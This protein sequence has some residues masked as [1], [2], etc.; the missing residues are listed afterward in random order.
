MAKIF[1]IIGF[2]IIV[3]AGAFFYFKQNSNN[4]AKLNPTEK[5]P[6]KVYTLG[7]IQDAN[8]FDVAYNGFVES[9]ASQGFKEGVNLTL[10]HSVVNGASESAKIATNQYLQQKVDLIVTIGVS[11]TKSA[12]IARKDNTTPIVFF[13]V[14]DPINNKIINSYQDPGNNVT[15]VDSSQNKLAPLRL[16]FLKQ[17]SPNIKKTLVFYNNPINAGLGDLEKAAQELKINLVEKKVTSL[18][19]LKKQINSINSAEFDS[20]IRTPD[21]VLAAGNQLLIDLSIRYKVPYIGTN[22]S[23]ADS[24][25]LMSYGPSYKDLGIQGASLAVQIL[26]GKSANSL[27]VQQADRPELVINKK[28]AQQINLQFPDEI[29]RKTNKVIE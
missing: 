15:G 11:P 17:V 22:S 24:G 1:L 27:P 10:L 29:L 2:I 28:T 12:Q 20:V 16:T 18:D 23:D 14:S 26:K 5:K 13:V 9:L 19:D 4:L 8:S 6:D 3:L 7:V 25:G 21:G